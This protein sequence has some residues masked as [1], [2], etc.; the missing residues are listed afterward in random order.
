MAI[1]NLKKSEVVEKNTTAAS[2][3]LGG[4]E[5]ASIEIPLSDPNLLSKFKK[6]KKFRI[7]PNFFF[8][9]YNT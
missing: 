6:I 9:L 4:P 1:V 7:V 2:T 3:Y 8:S 5:S